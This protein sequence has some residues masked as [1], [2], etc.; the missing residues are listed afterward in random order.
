[1]Q[2]TFLREQ[3]IAIEAEETESSWHCGKRQ[4]RLTFNYVE[5]VELGIGSRLVLEPEALFDEIFN[6]VK[7]EDRA[8]L[9]GIF[10][11]KT[12]NALT[13]EEITAL[14]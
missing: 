5:P 13:D 9:D 10:R 3:Y 14:S 8:Q 7:C 4:I 1:M 11:S 12:R 2:L 6:Y